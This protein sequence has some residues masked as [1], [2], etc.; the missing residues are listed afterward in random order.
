MEGFKVDQLARA[1]LAIAE[2]I[3]KLA[4]AVKSK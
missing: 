4:D 1:L 2:A 3:N